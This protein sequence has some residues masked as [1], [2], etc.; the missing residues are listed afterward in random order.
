MKGM[1]AVFL[2][3]NLLLAGAE[4]P[5]GHWVFDPK[6]V[7][8]SKVRPLAGEHPVHFSGAAEVHRH[9]GVG[10]LALGGANHRSWVS[11]DLASLKLP[12][13]KIT[14]ASWVRVDKP[15]RWGGICGA[16][17]DNGD[18]E[19]G[20]VLG[21]ENQRFNFG[22]NSMGSGRI[23]Y[24]ADKVDF[25]KGRWHHVAGTYD[26]REM[27]LY[28]NGRLRVSSVEQNGA[29]RYPP[30][31]RFEVG[32]YHDDDEFYRLTGG[33]HEVTLWRRALTG[34]EIE[35]LF[36]AKESQFPLPPGLLEITNGP[37]AD[38]LHRESI[39]LGWETEMPMQ[40]RVVLTGQRGGRREFQLGDVSVRHAVELDSL[41]PDENYTYRIHGVTADGKKW[42]SKL[43]T[44]DASFYYR[45]PGK[46]DV[47]S[48][49]ADNERSAMLKDAAL[50]IL[51]ESRVAHGYALV[52]GTA[53]GQLAYWLAR[54][55]DLQVIVVEP[56]A[57]KAQVA[58]AKLRDAGLYGI[59]AS[60]HQ[61]SLDDLPYGPYFANLIVS[62]SLLLDGKPPGRD[63]R[64]LWR[65]LRPT[66]GVVML[67]WKSGRKEIVRK[68]FAEGGVSEVQLT[69]AK[70]LWAFTRRG[71]LKGAGEWSHQYG[72]LDNTTNSQDDLVRGDM[73]ILWWGE[74]GPRPMPDRG[75]RNPAPLAVNGRLFVQGDRTFFGMDAYNGSILWTLSAP[76][77]RRSN[78]PR[79]GSN[80]VAAED[81]L[82]LAGGRYA[83]GLDAQTGKRK[84]KFSAPKERH[85][86]FLG[87][88][89]G[90]LLGS[91]VKPHS[92][93]VAD[94]GEWYDSTKPPEVARLVS[95]SLF[96][97]DRL[98][99]KQRWEYRG[100]QI[101][102]STITVADGVVYFVESRN[103]N[104]KS[105][106]TS[107]VAPEM[108]TKQF[109]VA[110]D[111]KNGGK[112]W[113]KPVDF[114]RC[115]IMLYLLHSD[116]TLVATGTDRGKNYHTY[117]FDVSSPSLRIKPQTGGVP[118]L[119]WEDHHVA[120]KDHHG[121]LLQHPLVVGGLFYSDNR[122]L[123]MRTG[124]MKRKDLPQ[125]RGCG[126]MAA[127]R[128][129]MF[130]RHHYHGMW[131]LEANKKIQFEGIRGG[132]WLGIIPA[133]GL[134]LAPESS[135][136]C[137]CAHS[138]QTSAAWVPRAAL[139][140]R[141][142]KVRQ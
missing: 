142:T 63:A 128:H 93:Y 102:N 72:G 18:Y 5:W 117:A 113:D 86:G 42:V 23:T 17:Q 104:V 48:P 100:G 122:A 21:Y 40:A 138:I 135:S 132:C 133:Q 92:A 134:M 4:A 50:K 24:L 109:L 59:R 101:M 129:S 119:L 39:R 69:E 60:V 81:F 107:R 90:H 91:S 26:G 36:K 75:G 71:K 29:I 98:T 68:W 88:L 7:A 79:D 115:E 2:L 54:G 44:F 116:G 66:G 15:L 141:G 1:W 108:L 47:P 46:P 25:V 34:E 77:I 83:I 10:Q 87:V 13:G 53:E 121:G 52:L 137:S 20:W 95:D 140:K 136:G 127:S 31:G 105:L 28:V 16:I 12:A 35:K 131:D 76:E 126:I 112:L 14:V 89:E 124:K 6:R 61:G 99:A 55:S 22:L 120:A 78:L 139:E 41:L 73:G 43:Y 11:D 33:I 64:E 65:V 82:Y 9:E 30:R 56:D 51:K 94:Q 49:F 96:S 110:I 57:A 19:R 58:R 45:L 80:M 27:R 3:S 74:P 38:W 118:K 37:F 8:G 125:R 106:S 85:W 103:V 123:D 62:G 84:L 97:F 114:S 111:L 67:G 32:A 130:Y 70:N